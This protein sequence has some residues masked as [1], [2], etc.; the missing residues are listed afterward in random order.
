[1]IHCDSSAVM[2]DQAN[3][4]E[5]DRHMMSIFVVQHSRIMMLSLNMVKIERGVVKQPS[6]LILLQLFNVH[7]LVFQALINWWY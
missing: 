5:I 4:D 2:N 1:M 3:P 7:F 6:Q